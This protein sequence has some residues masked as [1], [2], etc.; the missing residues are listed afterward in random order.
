MRTRWA[1]ATLLL[2][3]TLAG[4]ADTT[5]SGA[6]DDPTD[7]SSTST[8]TS[9]DPPPPE[10]ER[11]PYLTAEQVTAALGAPVVVTAG[12]VH[13][14]FFDPEGG[15]GVDGASVMLSRVNVQIEPAD[16]AAQTRALC[17]GEVT[18]VEVGDEA[19]ACVMGLGPQGQLY[20][21]RVLVTVNV[22]GAVDDA[23]GIGVA[24]ALLHEVTVP[25][26]SG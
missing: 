26:A 2:A 11:C 15:E 3:V 14:C 13:A 16:Y 4:C 18:D 17:Q 7:R 12:S 23:A 22:I 9:G 1:A 21:N 25:S 24:T 8:P 20:V 10:Q 6:S 19:F 5:S